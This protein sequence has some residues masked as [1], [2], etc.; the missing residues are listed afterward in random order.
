MVTAGIF[1]FKKN[2]HGRAGNR[3][4]DLVISSQRLWPLDHET[5]PIRL[6]IVSSV[7]SKDFSVFPNVHGLLKMLQM[8][9]S[10]YV[11][12]Q[13]R[14]PERKTCRRNGR[15]C[16]ELTTKRF[17]QLATTEQ[18]LDHKRVSR[19]RKENFNSGIRNYLKVF[20]LYIKSLVEKSAL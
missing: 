13:V 18:S 19:L 10:L 3:T 20:H 17:W 8:T 12:V 2:S 16:C 7:F 11:V 9:G 14:R 15:I 6:H 4:R 1:P 5:G